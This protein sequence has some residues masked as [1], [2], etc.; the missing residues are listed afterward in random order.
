MSANKQIVEKY[1]EGFRRS[2][3]TMVL[4]CLTDDVEWVMPGAF[5]VS[6]K[7]AFDK[8]IESD[9]YV[10]SPAIDVTRLTEEGDVVVAEGTVRSA[11]K[12]GGTLTCAFCDIFT[13]RDGKIRHLTSYVA[14]Q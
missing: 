12:E 8:E 3:H 10:G 9:C 11:R 1:M 5:H 7:E 14:E 2:D 13:M 4:G 6:G